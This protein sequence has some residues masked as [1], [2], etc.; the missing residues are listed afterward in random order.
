MIR[1]EMPLEVVAGACLCSAPDRKATPVARRLLCSVVDGPNAA[2]TAA[3]G[4]VAEDALVTYDPAWAKLGYD[5]AMREADH[6]I[7]AELADWLPPRIFDAHLHLWNFDYWGMPM[8]PPYGFLGHDGSMAAYKQRAMALFPGREVGGLMLPFPIKG[9]SSEQDMSGWAAEECRADGGLFAPAMLVTPATSFDDIIENVERFGFVCLKPYHCY[10]S[11]PNIVPSTGEPSDDT[12]YAEIS[13]FLTNEHCRAAHA[14]NLAVTLHMVKPR[15]LA[16]KQ[17]QAT[18]R[19]YCE[20]FPNMRLILAHCARGF[21][22][23]HTIEGI[24]SLAGLDNVYF[25]T[26]AICEP[27]AIHACIAAFG[28]KKVLY[29][30]D[31][32]VS[33]VRGR[34]V[35]VGDQFQ[36]GAAYFYRMLCSAIFVMD[37][38]VSRRPKRVLMGYSRWMPGWTWR[39]WL[40]WLYPNTAQ[41]SPSGADPLNTLESAVAMVGF[42][43]LRAVK[44]ACSMANCSAD[45]VKDIMCEAR[46]LGSRTL[47]IDSAQPRVMQP[48]QI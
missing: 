7:Q 46:L 41:L 29:G 43:T 37:R 23:F 25:D 19:E 47:H 34:C 48:A 10:S 40:Q 45:D 14:K 35:S 17:N 22:M 27:G 13:D 24:H 26:A 42:E 28:A 9:L 1:Y 38:P 8:A 11:G 20:R 12:A 21:N 30:S 16:D 32:P 33:E 6:Q 5:W 15:A 36:V 4:G 31:W 3:E 44:T 18:I 2:V 39:C